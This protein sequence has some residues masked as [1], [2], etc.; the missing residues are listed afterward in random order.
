MADPLLTVTLAILFGMVAQLFAERLRVPAIVLMLGVGVGLGSEG[1]RWIDPDALGGS[2]FGVVGLAV[3]VV[4]FEGAMALDV[5]RLRERGPM[6]SR[7][8]LWGGLLSVIGGTLVSWWLLGFS[9][10]VSLLFG[11]LVM[12]TGPTV[13]RPLLRRIPIRRG[14]HDVLEAEGIFI[15]ALGTVCV[16]V[17][18]R[19]A[20]STGERIRLGDTL[21]M[22]LIQA[23]TGLLVGATVA[24]MLIWALR[25]G[26]L[27]PPKLAS[28]FLLAVVL[29]SWTV[30]NALAPESG[31]VA[32]IIA[33]L[34]VGNAR[35]PTR[36]ALLDFK[37]QLT[38]MLLGM[39]F[40]L[41]S[42]DVE[43]TDVLQ[44]GWGGVLVVLVL[45]LVVRPLAVFLTTRGGLLTLG[46]RAFIA[47]MG[48]RGIVAAAMATLAALEL[49]AI[50]AWEADAL[51][52]MVFLVIASTVVVQGLL[53]GPISRLL[54]V[55]RAQPRGYVILGANALGRLVA[56]ALRAAG[57]P[58]VLVDEDDA[59]VRAAE[60]SGL[61]VIY[62]ESLSE[63]TLARTQPEVRAAYVGLTADAQ[64]NLLWAERVGRAVPQ[65][66]RVVAAER[67]GE[68]SDPLKTAREGGA[69][70][71]FGGPRRL[72]KW[73]ERAERGEIGLHFCRLE[74]PGHDSLPLGDEAEGLA[75]LMVWREG[76]MSLIDD[77]WRPQR[78]D[79]AAFLYDRA[80]EEDPTGWLLAHGW[81]RLSALPPALAAHSAVS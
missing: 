16:V 71:L 7:L 74:R 14:A 40:V 18:L 70:V 44:L 52:A 34:I 20:T 28:P 4:L 61:Q 60:A 81:S 54:G 15:D 17:A 78:G 41:L 65:M 26:D 2:L 19:I 63:R 24:V 12:V 51:R 55:R 62:G 35:L 23:G 6:V 77:H 58:V 50:G 69:T 66:R 21:E 32:V 3:S 75:P 38:P 37:E 29:A 1:L 11:T 64:K 48:P 8:V 43:L 27:V 76:R 46:E 42:A 79:M 5:R 56:R 72:S 25:R 22:L 57:E 68:T 36:K 39:L 59:A 67:A 30:S 47:W 80:C 45:M 73:V 13:I 9:W 10:Q 53:A 31:V 33:G 49:E